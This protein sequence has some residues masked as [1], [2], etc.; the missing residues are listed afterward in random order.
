M[1]IRYGA[2]LL[3]HY[4]RNLN[5]CQPSN[6]IDVEAIS[7]LQGFQAHTIVNEAFMHY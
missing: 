5:I 1:F 7:N 2:V 6:F 4:N 3:E